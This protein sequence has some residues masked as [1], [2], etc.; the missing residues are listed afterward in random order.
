MA[1]VQAVRDRVPLRTFVSL[2]VCLFVCAAWAQSLE[3]IEL[4]HRTA[5]DIIP[6][7]QP[8]LEP[9]AALSGA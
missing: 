1:N 2:F 6:V 9:G 8:L 4:E 7:L 3:V 5:E